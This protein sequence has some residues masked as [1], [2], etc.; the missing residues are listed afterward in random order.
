MKQFFMKI[1]VSLCALSSLQGMEVWR[2]TK[3][4]E[5]TFLIN[6]KKQ[7][8]PFSKSPF[9]VNQFSIYEDSPQHFLR[10]TK[11]LPNDIKQYIVNKV[12]SLLTNEFDHKRA[13]MLLSGNDPILLLKL[14]CRAQKMC[15]LIIG[16]KTFGWKD[17]IV[18]TKDTQEQLF[19]VG[20]PNECY[21]C[22]TGFDNNTIEG[23]CAPCTRTLYCLPECFYG[24]VRP[25][26]NVLRNQSIH[27][28]KDLIIQ[29]AD[30]SLAFL[31]CIPSCTAGAILSASF[32]KILTACFTFQPQAWCIPIVCCAMNVCAFPLNRLLIQQ[33]CGSC[34]CTQTCPATKERLG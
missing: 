19:V 1:V 10:T 27:I 24:A 28:K 13:R 2:E 22:I 25:D 33:R 34:L 3:K 5:N 31:G 6:A 15:P 11:A 9:F 30:Y 17:L 23:D 7:K 16:N 8:T 20:N 26:L 12:L 21:S 18:L 29:R 4:S 14:I 32:I